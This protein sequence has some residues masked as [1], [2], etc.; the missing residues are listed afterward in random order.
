M[1][2]KPGRP[3]LPS[4]A[5][6]RLS[7]VC[8]LIAPPVHT[9]ESLEKEVKDSPSI[10]ADAAQHA[11]TRLII[12]TSETT[13][14]PTTVLAQ[15]SREEVRPRSTVRHAAQPTPPPPPLPLQPKTKHSARS[16]QHEARHP[17]LTDEPLL[18]SPQVKGHL[19]PLVDHDDFSA[20]MRSSI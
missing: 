18:S 15:P 19:S 5:R 9:W 8:G 11:I 17:E 13:L 16:T 12:A 3:I 10:Q 6:S 20:F 14:Y 4:R 7:F 1:G 2:P